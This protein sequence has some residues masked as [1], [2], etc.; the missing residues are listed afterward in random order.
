MSLAKEILVKALQDIQIQ[1][2]TYQFMTRRDVTWILQ[3]KM[4]DLIA[5]E[6]YP[7]EIYH[8]YPLKRGER[9]WKD[10][11]L[12]VLPQGMSYREIFKLNSPVELVIRLLFE[13]SWHRVDICEYHLPYV[14]STNIETEKEELQSLISEHKTKE[15]QLI[16]IDEYSRHQTNLAND[17]THKW[18]SWG[19][20]DDPGLNVSVLMV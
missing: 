7:F 8:S 2:P 3:K 5:K 6:G 20:Y 16:L 11:E 9:T 4:R 10:Y 19:N 14:L 18:Q 12:V 13:P 17:A 15:A 1:Y